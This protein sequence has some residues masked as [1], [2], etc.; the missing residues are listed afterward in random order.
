LA[1][2]DREALLAAGDVALGEVLR[3][4]ASTA[5]G[6]AVEDDGGLVLVSGSRTWPGPYHN[7][8]LRLDRT[9]PPGD[10]LA[11]AAAFFAD[12]SPGYCV[13]IAEAADDDLE[14]AALAQGLLRI[15][16]TGVPRMAIERPLPPPVVPAGVKLAMVV[17]E[18]G[19]RDFLAVNVAAYA[20]DPTPPDAAEAQVSCLAALYGPTVRAV[21]ARDDGRPV[22][23]AMVVV[24]GDAASIQS[25][26]TTPAAQRRGLGE[27]CTAWAVNAGFEMGARAAVLEASEA[28]E[29]LYRRMGFVEVSRYRWC[30]GRPA[31]PPSTPHA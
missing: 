14:R 19:R 4:A 31:A 9:L 20:E 10:V 18:P 2:V 1:T 22:A 23:A 28:G 7:G 16:A 13:W 17:D 27:A 15:S 29:P 5:A 25:V 26:G 30:F 11:R 24:L 6:G 8:A 21:V 3:L 12:R